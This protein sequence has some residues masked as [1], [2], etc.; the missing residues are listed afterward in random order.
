M[1][2]IILVTKTKIMINPRVPY[3]VLLQTI[4]LKIEHEKDHHKNG[5]QRWRCSVDLKTLRSSHLAMELSQR[6]TP[7]RPSVYG[8]I[9]LSSG[10]NELVAIDGVATLVGINEAIT[11]NTEK[12]GE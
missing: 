11:F 4:S 7:V 9:L 12:K 3:R 2:W 6:F 1:I 5:Y 10:V 8:R